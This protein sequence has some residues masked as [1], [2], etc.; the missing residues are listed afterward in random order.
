M[1]HHDSYRELNAKGV[2]CLISFPSNFR[3]Q[4]NS[5]GDDDSI[6]WIKRNSPCMA[7]IVVMCDMT[8]KNEGTNLGRLHRASI[9]LNVG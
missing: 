5:H 7:A 3:T 2:I 6:S 8:I 9:I 1:S 4:P